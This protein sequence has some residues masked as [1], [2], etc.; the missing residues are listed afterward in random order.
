[1]H[2]ILMV[3]QL[4]SRI[5]VVNSRKEDVSRETVERSGTL[6]IIEFIFE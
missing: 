1:M 2:L 5:S 4:L 6:L 3:I